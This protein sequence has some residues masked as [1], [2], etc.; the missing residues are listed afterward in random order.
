MMAAGRLVFLFCFCLLLRGQAPPAPITIEQA[1]A[2]ALRNNPTLAAERENTPLAES[3]IHTAYL[4]PNPVLSVAADYLDVLGTHFSQATNNAGPAEGSGRIDFV[5]EGPG[6]RANRIAVAQQSKSVTELSLQNTIR[7]LILDVQNAF[8][9]VLLA[10]AAVALTQENLKSL[11]TLVA[12]STQRVNAGNLTG[13]DL[14]RAKLA[15][16]QFKNEAATAESRL[17][18]TRHRL[19][20]LMGR[21]T[22]EHGFDVVGEMRRD[23]ERIEIQPLRAQAQELRPDVQAVVRDQ[24]RSAADLKLQLAQAKIDYTVGTQYHRQQSPTGKGNSLGIF[25]SVPLRVFD[26]NQGE[27]ERATFEH[28]QLED[29][30]RAVRGAAAAD[31]ESAYEQYAIAGT[32]LDNLEGEILG[33]AREVRRAA[34]ASFKAAETKLLDFLDAQRAYTDTMQSYNDARGNYAKSLYLLEA[35]TGRNLVARR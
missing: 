31:V 1:V 7:T 35:V 9:D 15:A 16:T 28:R 20:L 11:N 26:R 21:Q 8:V 27:I 12:S 6:K 23:K 30:L 29:R 33:E 25:V 14:L 2:E 10:K 32:M 34:E 17:H 24:A 5:F 4:R 3:R 13:A 19:Q 22:F 18:S